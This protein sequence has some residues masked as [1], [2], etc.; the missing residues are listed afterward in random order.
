MAVTPSPLNIGCRRPANSDPVLQLLYCEV[1]ISIDANLARDAHRFHGEVFHSQLGVFD[2]RASGGQSI[3]TSGTYRAEPIV[4][5]DYV[6]VTGKQERALTVG[7]NQ[8]R[9]QMAKG[10]IF[11][12]FLGELDG[13]LL[14]V[15]GML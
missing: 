6:A 5:L 4:G 2:Q 13:R 1:S 3:S 7:H 12:P 14:Q 11:A 8:Q 9:L 10:A 15:A